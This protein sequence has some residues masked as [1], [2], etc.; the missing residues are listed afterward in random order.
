MTEIAPTGWAASFN[1]VV[2]G[3]RAWPAQ[4]VVGRDP[5]DGLSAWTL[6][7]RIII[8]D[9]IKRELLSHKSQASHLIKM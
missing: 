3:P 8:G 7:I 9:S 1:W 2:P 6:S 5:L 4:P